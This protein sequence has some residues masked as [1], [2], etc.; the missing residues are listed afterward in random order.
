[1]CRRLQSITCRALQCL[2]TDVVRVWTG[3]VPYAG[4][5][6]ALL[7][8]SKWNPS[9]EKDFPGTQLRCEHLQLPGMGPSYRT[10]SSQQ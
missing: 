2:A 9:K 8:P 5:G 3:F 6:Y 7:I 4:E 1:M 10:Y